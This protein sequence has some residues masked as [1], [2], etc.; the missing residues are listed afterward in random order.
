MLIINESG[1][2]MRSVLCSAFA[3]HC[4]LVVIRIAAYRTQFSNRIYA[5]LDLQQPI[6]LNP[7]KKCQKSIKEDARYP[8]YFNFFLEQ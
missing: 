6:S 7:Y 5:R 3:A 8:S 4:R 1:A 2:G